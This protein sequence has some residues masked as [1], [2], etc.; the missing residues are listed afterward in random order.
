MKTNT[1]RM[2][3]RHDAASIS[4]TFKLSFR[5]AYTGIIPYETLNQII[6]QRSPFWWQN[7]IENH[8]NIWAIEDNSIVAGYISFGPNRHETFANDAEI[9]GIYIR[10]EYQGNGFG[11]KLFETSVRELNRVKLRGKL[12]WVIEENQQAIDF[13]IAMGGY[14]C[15]DSSSLHEGTSLKKIAICWK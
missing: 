2:A 1:I 6:E 11:K 8:S 13:F 12:T 7:Y 3:I 9:Y 15:G 5:H 4:R 14:I 10:P